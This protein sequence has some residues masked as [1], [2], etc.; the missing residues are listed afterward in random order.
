MAHKL[1]IKLN[2]ASSIDG[3]IA[4]FEKEKLT[5]GSE[6]DRYLMEKLRADADCVI[7]GA[8]NVKIEDTPLII[9]NSKLLKYRAKFK[10]SP[11]PVNVVISSNLNFNFSESQFFSSI[12]T[13]KIIFTIKNVSKTL[14]EK[15]SRY[16]R[17]IKVGTKNKKVDLIDVINYLKNRLNYRNILVEGGGE[18][19]FSMLSLNLVDEIYITL[20]P[21]IFGGRDVPTIVMGHGFDKYNLKKLQ[22]VSF[23]ESKAGELFL[24]YKILDKRVKIIKNQFTKK[25]SQIV[26]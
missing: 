24:H 13:T 10:K 5:F 17:V 21:Y 14:E 11:Q 1:I 12:N 15:A 19:N 18:L 4:T 6:E 25:G 26:C 2:M 23:K 3:K 22:L 7:I 20:C 9:R 8:N 16:A